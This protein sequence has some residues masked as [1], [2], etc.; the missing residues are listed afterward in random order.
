MLLSDNVDGDKIKTLSVVF[1]YMLALQTK[2]TSLEPDKRFIRL[3]Q[4]VCLVCAAQ[5]YYIHNGVDMLLKSLSTSRN[6]S[7]NKYYNLLL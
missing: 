4:N 6:P 5:L 2:L 7:F 3:N 1:F